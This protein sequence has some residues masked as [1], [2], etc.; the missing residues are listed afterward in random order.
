MRYM[1]LVYS[2][3]GPDGLAPEEAERIRAGHRT[4]M[5]EATRR[6]VLIGA[7]PLAPTSTATTVRMQ[8]EKVFVTDGPFAETKEH[9]A[10]YYIIECENLDEA[11]EWAARIPTACQ[12][13]EGCIEIRP[14]RWQRAGAE[15]ASVVENSAR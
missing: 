10:G 4:V 11:I 2:N 8:G 3:E 14:M 7:E 9:L 12:G 6:G 5:E 13:R 15:P 1:M